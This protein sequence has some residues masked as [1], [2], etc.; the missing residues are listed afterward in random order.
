M[1]LQ[2][3]Q[4]DV[5]GSCGAQG[6]GVVGLAGHHRCRHSGRGDGQPERQARWKLRLASCRFYTRV[7]EAGVNQ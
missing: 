4:Q 6:G 1:F 7:N 3:S 2:A 5:L